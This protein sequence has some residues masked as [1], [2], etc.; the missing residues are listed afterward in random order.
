M[1]E[2]NIRVRKESEQENEETIEGAWVT[3]L[4]LKNEGWTECQA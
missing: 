4:D 3:E 1:M 2:V